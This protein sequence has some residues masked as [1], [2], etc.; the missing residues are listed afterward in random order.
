MS[1]YAQA[2]VCLRGH[3][4]TGNT[5]YLSEIP[6]R[7]S[8][9]GAIVIVDCRACDQRIQGYY[10]SGVLGGPAYRPPRFCDSCGAPHPW[11][12]R[13]TRIYELENI[14]DAEDIG[15]AER[16]LARE[17]LE[18]LRQPDLTEEEQVE[19]WLKVKRYAPGLLTTGRAI[20][21]SVMTAAIK[22]QMGL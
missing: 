7:C 17:Q 14:L 11:A 8:D 21:E 5:D 1:D 6:A 10:D 22:A 4:I 16:L 19:R 12:D 20:A 15:E 9:C 18:A 3:A 2:A 13:R